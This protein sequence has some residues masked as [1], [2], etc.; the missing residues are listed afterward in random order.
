MNRLEHYMSVLVGRL[1]GYYEVGGL[2]V[3]DGI[4]FQTNLCQYSGS[5]ENGNPNRITGTATCGYVENGINYAFSGG[6][7]ANRQ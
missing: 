7:Q 6:W 3:I 1:L 4:S 5:F 2:N